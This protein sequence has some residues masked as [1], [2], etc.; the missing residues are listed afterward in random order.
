MI[1]SRYTL[2]SKT[3]WPTKNILALKLLA[4]RYQDLSSRSRVFP[5]TILSLFYFGKFWREQRWKENIE[6]L[7]ITIE[8]R[9]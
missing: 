4:I 8:K 6:V 5:T 1:V 9:C 3:H 7:Y 2:S